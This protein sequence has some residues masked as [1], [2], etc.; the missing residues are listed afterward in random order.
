MTGWN[1][2]SKRNWTA[3]P[4]L[5]MCN[6]CDQTGPNFG[7]AQKY[8]FNPSYKICSKYN[9]TDENEKLTRFFFFW[10][11]EYLTSWV[12]DCVNMYTYFLTNLTSFYKKKWNNFFSNSKGQLNYCNKK[13]DQIKPRSHSK[14]ET[15]CRRPEDWK[16]KKAW[17]WST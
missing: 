5:H 12:Y 7:R 17:V 4:A 13:I 6:R 2:Y 15:R 16:P 3:G 9:F 8:F 1:P 11:N 14:E 10:D